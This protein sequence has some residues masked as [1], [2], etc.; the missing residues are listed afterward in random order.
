M[1]IS[2]SSRRLLT[3]SP[4]PAKKT[5]SVALWL[6]DALGSVTE[7]GPSA[8]RHVL[9]EVVAMTDRRSDQVSMKEVARI[10]F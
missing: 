7:N 1:L 9:P 2:W 10:G 6:P 3:I 8:D 4:R 5:K